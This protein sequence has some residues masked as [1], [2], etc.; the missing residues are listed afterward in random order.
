MNI[1]KIS[2]LPPPWSALPTKVSIKAGFDVC[3][4]R[5]GGPSEECFFLDFCLE[6]NRCFRMFKKKSENKHGKL[7]NHHFSI[8]QEIQYIFKMWMFLCHLEREEGKTK[9]SQV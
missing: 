5:L 4:G 7:E 1:K 2:E 8:L 9:N 3:Q 6:M